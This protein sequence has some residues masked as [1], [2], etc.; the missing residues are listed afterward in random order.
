[1]NT[2]I[3]Y[4]FITTTALTAIYAAVAAI[5]TLGLWLLHANRTRR[6][7]DDLPFVSV[8]VA[9]RNESANIDAC[10]SS[11]TAQDYP[12]DRYEILLIDDHSTDDTRAR[13]DSHRADL[14]T[15]RVIALA[16]AND[17]SVTGKQHALDAG[18]RQ[19]R[20]EIIAS[21]D[22]D[23]VVPT[24]WLSGIVEQF[25]EKTGVV[26]G[27]SMLDAPRDGERPFIKIQSLELLGLFAAFAG[28]IRWNVA[29]AC[30]GNNLAYRR[31]VYEELGGFM[32]MGFTVA[33][34][35][36]FLQ[37]VNRHTDWNIRVTCDGDVTVR[38]HP[39]R[40][41]RDFL[42]QRL[43]WASNSLENRVEALAFMV[44]AYLVNLL[45]PVTLGLGIVGI[46]PMWWAV[47]IAAMKWTPEALL[48]WRGL[49]LFK[50]RDLLIYAPIMA[51]FHSMYVLIAGL[52]GLSGRAVWKN[53]KHSATGDTPR[54]L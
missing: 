49:S 25:D 1:M 44:V 12:T 48:L 17:P 43:R 5:F 50:R 35:N 46:A 54:E 16:D 6:A 33:E 28:S 9:A 29:L 47:G 37:W 53:R 38:T 20:G 31:V 8:I 42:R 11:L 51:P 45:V 36:M 24:T 39:Q 18:I 52:L 15:L 7:T 21:T 30:T 23:C 41:F 14:D 34:D 4:L 40:T 26:A 32:K 19:S 13:A 22:A 3:Y 10:L 2:A 27:F